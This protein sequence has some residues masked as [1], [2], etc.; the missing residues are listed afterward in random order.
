MK[1]NEN[2]CV[3]CGTCNAIYPNRVESDGSK[4]KI[5]D[6]LNLTDEEKNE[7]MNICPVGAIEN[8]N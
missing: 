7:L 1:I 6:D 2:K 4:F 3:L 5:K 8:S